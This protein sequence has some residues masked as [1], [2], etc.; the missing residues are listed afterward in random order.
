MNAI[1]ELKNV[2]AALEAIYAAINANSEPCHYEIR[3]AIDL[4]RP[5]YSQAIEELEAEEN[6][7]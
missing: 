2:I 1:A 7:P 5:V 6:E 4:S 3:R